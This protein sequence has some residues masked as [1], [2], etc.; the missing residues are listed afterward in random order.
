MPTSSGQ[1][2]ELPEPKLEVTEYRAEIKVC[3]HCSRLNR[4]SFPEGVSAPA[5][6]GPKFRSF[7]LYLHHQQLLPANRIRQLCT[8]LFGVS[9]SEA[10]LF[11]ETKTC[12]HRLS[13]YENEVIAR[14]QNESVLQVDES[15]VRV[16]EKLH[17]IHSAS[18]DKY[19]FYGIHRKRGKEA[20]DEFQIL[21]G[22]NGTLI[23]DFRKTYFKYDCNH[24]LCN[25][26]ILRELK[27]LYETR[28]QSWA[29][30]LSNLLLKMNAYVD[31][32]RSLV[33]RLTESQK[34]PLIE[35]FRKIVSLGEKANPP[36]QP[37]E[38]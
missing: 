19:T 22:F 27:F 37:T 10:T 18:T 30:K 26:H 17:W 23:H 21:P 16:L 14:L 32:R 1:V 36:T 7:L 24:G 25:A 34:Q 33:D 11:K 8:D 13:D 6:Y 9:V 5:Q 35:R 38:S 2:F 20:T 29:E 4:A 15:G 3:P 12:H 31:E 28:D